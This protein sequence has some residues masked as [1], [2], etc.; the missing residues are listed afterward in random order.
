MHE[1]IFSPPPHSKNNGYVGGPCKLPSS[2]SWPI[3]NSGSSLFHLMSI[4]L[5]WLMSNNDIKGNQLWISIFVSYDRTEYSHYSKMSSDEPNHNDARIILHDMS[6][7]PRNEHSD[8]NDAIGNVSLK[9]NSN[10][11]IDD[12]ASYIGGQPTWVQDPITIKGYQWHASIYGPD[13]DQALG[14]DAGILSDGVG[15]IFLKSSLEPKLDE[16]AGRFYLQI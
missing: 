5:N 16:M 14:N 8:G 12:I 6:G 4:P 2:L 3:A 7:P 1:L 10:A 15:Y 13:I 11:S 9:S